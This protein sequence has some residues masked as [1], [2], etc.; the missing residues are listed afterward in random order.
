[1]VKFTHD[2]I[3]ING[4]ERPLY[5]GSIHYWRTKKKDWRLVLSQIRGMGFEIVETYIPWSVH[6]YEEGKYDFGEIEEEKDL[7]LFLTL[8]EEMNLAVIVRPG[9]HINAEMS[10]FGYPEWILMDEE[11]QAKN[12]WGTTVLYPYATGPFPIPSYASDKLYEK[13]EIYFQKLKPILQRHC[14]GSGCICLIQA[15]NETCNFFRDR[16]YI[17]DYSDCSKAQYHKFLVE[18]YGTVAAM[19]ERYHRNYSG[20]QET[21]PPCGFEEG[22]FSSLCYY[23][24]W[25]E[26]KEY[27]ILAALGRLVDIIN[28]LELPVP[29]F[30]NCAYQNYTPVSVQRDEE[31]PG[32]M[33]AGIDA[34]PEPG[35]AAM[36]KERIRYLAGSSRF[37]FVPEFGSGS[38]FDREMLLT[39][40]EERF[41]YLYSVMNGLKGVNFYMLAE[42]DRWTGCPVTNDGRIRKPYYEMFSDLLR[43]LKDHEIY[44]FNRSP[45]VLILKNYDM[46]RL[47][48]LHSV[49][50]CNTFSSNCFIKG[51]DI[52]AALFLPEGE[53]EYYLD[54]ELNYWDDA[55]V[56]GLAKRFDEEHE[57]YDYSDEYLDY[58]RWLQYD[59]IAAASGDIMDAKTQKRLADFAGM[60]GKKVILGPVIPWYDRTLKA[61]EILKHMV[62]EGED[63]GILFAKEPGEIGAGF[64][65]HL[66]RSR[67]YGCGDP[68]IELA[69]H[70]RENSRDHLLYTANLSGKEKT[71]F[72]SVSDEPNEHISESIWRLPRGSKSPL[73]TA[74]ALNASAERRRFSVLQGPV[75][76]NM[77]KN[78]ITVQIPAYTVAIL[79]VEENV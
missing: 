33:V 13:T 2:G 78:G 60:P 47:K 69:V 67:E 4:V 15:D 19:N 46:G 21:E 75:K 27:Q 62:E 64:W 35:D 63:S 10:G 25:V 41:G 18:R 71:A 79:Y 30:H 58:G 39:A 56:K 24:D 43:M 48:A 34:Y 53:P 65:E 7:D 5:S 14:G 68:E 74:G 28:R 45:R 72:I 26:F 17:M 12:P 9:P 76:I 23:L 42:R 70:R 31:I 50:D 29:I 77:E 51:P 3:R 36:L 37:P 59:V 44:H 6:E 32:L 49:M 20:F 61:C 1:M 52:P 73:Q 57:I 66:R 16:P 55:W 22:D 54:R 11:I 8:C 38:W 40:E